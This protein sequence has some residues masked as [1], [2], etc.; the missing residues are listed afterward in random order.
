MKKQILAALLAAVTAQAL[1]V[2]SAAAQAYPDRPIRLLVGFGPGSTTDVSSRILGEELSRS[3]GQQIVVESKPGA[4]SNIAAA[5]VA[6]SPPDGYMLFHVTVANAINPKVKKGEADWVDPLT[7]LTPVARVS[8]VPFVLVV[9]P[10]VKATSVRELVALA[11]AEPGKLNYGSAGRGTMQHLS[12]ELFKSMTGT[13]LVHVPYQ[14]V[15]QAVQDLLGGSIQVMFLASSSAVGPI[16]AKRLRALAWTTAERGSLLAD[17]PTLAEAGLAGYETS[18]W[19]GIAGPKGLP[20]AIR[21]KLSAAITAAVKS[22][23]VAQAFRKIGIEPFPAAGPQF[24]AYMAAESAKW[25]PVIEKTSLG[26]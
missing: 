7:E 23:A 6:K 26:N 2:A 17:L 12:G 18:L 14:A 16:E 3:L 10:A 13:N 21:D 5:I 4:A 24:G 20:D 22:D 25:G 9:N 1:M 8:S 11:K 19:S 15:G